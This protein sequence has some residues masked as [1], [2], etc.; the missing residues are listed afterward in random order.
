MAEEENKDSGAAEAKA[1]GDV[2]PAKAK[3]PILA[4]LLGIQM[5]AMM[6]GAGAILKATLFPHKENMSQKSM[7]ER[8]IASV[9]DQASEVQLVD[10]DEF[11]VNLPGRHIMSVKLNIEVSNAKTADVIKERRAEL[12]SKILEILAAQKPE[13]VSG[14]QGKLALKDSIREGI[15]DELLLGNKEFKGIVRDIYFVEFML[16]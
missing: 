10:V 9:H 15:N 2:P 11:K 7:T 16:L 4:L 3:I 6:G 1:E 13:E 12:R 8:A 5:I 14:V